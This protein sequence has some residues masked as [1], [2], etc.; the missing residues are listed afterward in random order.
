MNEQDTP[1]VA[2]PTQRSRRSTI[3]AQFGNDRA[4]LVHLRWLPA[5]RS[6]TLSWAIFMAV[7]LEAGTQH[8]AIGVEYLP[9]KQGL[10]R[11]REFRSG[12]DQPDPDLATNRDVSETL[13]ARSGRPTAR[14][15]RPPNCSASAARR[16][17]RRSRGCGF[18]GSLAL[19]IAAASKLATGPATDSRLPALYVGEQTLLSNRL[20]G[21]SRLRSYLPLAV[22]PG[23]CLTP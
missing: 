23:Q 1:T 17:G 10:T 6:W 7:R 16:C 9:W 3:V 12:R 20:I 8:D 14:S 13:P 15:S 4:D 2:W 22:S 19:G 5:I 11:L 18:A 21:P